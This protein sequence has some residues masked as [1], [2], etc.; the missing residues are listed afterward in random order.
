[1]IV[2]DSDAYYA[3]QFAACEAVSPKRKFKDVQSI[4]L[5]RRL[6]AARE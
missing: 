2:V 6:C 5:I 1:M 4:S 3:A